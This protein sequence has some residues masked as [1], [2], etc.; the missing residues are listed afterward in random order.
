MARNF[1]QKDIV[2][3]AVGYDIA[4]KGLLLLE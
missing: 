2:V 4:P 1:V 3:V